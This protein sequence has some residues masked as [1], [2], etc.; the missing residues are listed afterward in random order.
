[1]RTPELR[2]GEPRR[3]MLAVLLLAGIFAMHGVQIVCG[4]M[5]S[6]TF[7]EAGPSARDTHATAGRAQSKTDVAAMRLVGPDAVASTAHGRSAATGPVDPAIRVHARGSE[8]SPLPTDVGP[9]MG[10]CVAVL[11]GGV[12]LF[13]LRLR[14]GRGWAARS[15]SAI[16]MSAVVSSYLRSRRRRPRSF[17]RTLSVLCVLRT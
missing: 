7:G 9:A 10:L 13:V 8:P 14:V 11:V 1:M 17:A 2:A 5:G 3:L 15:A 16:S 4:H 12:V 6:H